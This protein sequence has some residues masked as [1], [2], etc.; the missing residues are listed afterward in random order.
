MATEIVDIRFCND[1]VPTLFHIQENIKTSDLKRAYKKVISDLNFDPIHEWRKVD[2]K[3]IIT[4]AHIHSLATGDYSEVEVPYNED[5]SL[6]DGFFTLE[7]S[8]EEFIEIIL[9]LIRIHL[10]SLTFKRVIATD[11]FILS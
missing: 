10:R 4:R 6:Q 7:C 8:D 9:Q 5:P 11:T 1:E 2:N 3:R